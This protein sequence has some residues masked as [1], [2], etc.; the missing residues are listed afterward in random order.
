MTEN[1]E[2]LKEILTGSPSSETFLVILG[3]IKKN[4]DLKTVIP[5]CLKALEIYPHNIHI[6]KFLAEAYFENGQITEAESELK[7]VIRGIEELASSY[8]LQA[9]ILKQQ[10]RDEEAIESLKFFLTHYPEDKEANTLIESLHSRFDKVPSKPLEA[11]EYETEEVTSPVQDE[12][13]EIVTPTLAELFFDQ[14]KM[15][16]A[17]EIYEKILLKNP[18]DERSRQRIDEISALMT[19][20]KPEEIY[21]E[22]NTRKKTEKMINALESWLEDIRKDAGKGLSAN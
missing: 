8:L 20:E 12:S 11:V 6:R 13:P 22:D 5:E 15:E 10:N 9:N 3:R 21:E 17:I 2:L 16:K 1:N 18:D 14:G 19:A 7:K 4:G